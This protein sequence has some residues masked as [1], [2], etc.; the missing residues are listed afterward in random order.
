MGIFVLFSGYIPTRSR[1][2]ERSHVIF[3]QCFAVNLIISIIIQFP[4]NSSDFPIKNTKM[5]RFVNFY[6][7]FTVFYVTFTLKIIIASFFH[8]HQYEWSIMK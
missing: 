2:H 8:E 4:K 7:F 6:T 1:K 3:F 5:M